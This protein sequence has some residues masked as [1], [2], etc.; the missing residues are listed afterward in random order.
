MTMFSLLRDLIPSNISEL[1]DQDQNHGMHHDSPHAR[2][3]ISNL[4][5]SPEPRDNK[6]ISASIADDR[7]GGEEVGGG[8]G[9][10]EG[11][12]SEG[13]GGR[14]TAHVPRTEP[15]RIINE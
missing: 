5:F 7:D 12:V 6:Q 8:G 2:M 3:N 11:G 1:A 15:S 4:M 9:G 10:A 13:A 14:S